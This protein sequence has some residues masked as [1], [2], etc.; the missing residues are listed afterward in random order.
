MLEPVQQKSWDRNTSPQ[1]PS[2]A[3]SQAKS[4]SVS[5]LGQSMY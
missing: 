5:S 1:S 3:S 2:G 4:H